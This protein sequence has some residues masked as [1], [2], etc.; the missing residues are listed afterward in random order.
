MPNTP[1]YRIAASAVFLGLSAAGAQR[2]PVEVL[3]SADALPPHIA[4]RF[5]DAAAKA[6]ESIAKTL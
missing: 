6:V 5:G 3:Q 2:P 1:F 4:G